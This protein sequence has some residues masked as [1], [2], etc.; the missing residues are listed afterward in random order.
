M[1]SIRIHSRRQFLSRGLG[2]VGVGAALP[3]FLI[4]SALAGPQA[5]ADEPIVVAL[6]LTGGP[7][8]LS[9]VPPYRDDAYYGQRPTLGMAAED[10]LK[11]ND[12]VGLHPQLAGLKAL[13]DQ[14]QMAVVLGTGYPNFNLSHFVGRDI[15]EAGRSG[16]SSG[17]PRATGW[18]GRYLDHL[19][20]TAPS[21][22]LNVAV[23]PDRFPLILTGERHPGVGFA[24]P[25]SF[26][27][28]G[29]QTPRAQ[30]LYQTLHA[31]TG[32][33]AGDDLQFIRQTAVNAN[34]AS[35]RI[36]E[37]AG[38]YRTPVSYPDT[39]FGNSVR[40]IAGLINGRLDTR[41]Y[42]AAQGIAIFG[43][44]D[45]HA[46]QPRRLSVLLEEL[47]DTV[48][49]FYQDL[50]RCGNAERVVTFTFSEFGRRVPENYSGGTDHGLAQPM[51]LFGPGV[52]GGVYGTQPSL[53]ELDENENLKME[54]DFRRVY[55]AILDKWLNVPPQKILGE[56]Y[57]PIDCIA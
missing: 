23:G 31:A 3:H 45:T 5:A 24:S 34:A 40:T 1:S 19:L 12:Q 15:W 56:E 54:V 2:L 57:S 39:Q 28:T 35:E 7:D 25:D 21:P 20:P 8:G 33:P 46:D 42:Y 26:R 32:P 13:Y 22:T 16:M 6:L 14:G 11:L 9:V 41:V 36:R 51:F 10:V 29:A 44:Y 37:L 50:K 27:F 48:A 30:Q 18:L 4:R 38:R 53:A 55:A 52:K 49:A 17:H 47:S 43:G